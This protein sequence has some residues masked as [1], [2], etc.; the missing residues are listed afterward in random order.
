[1]DAAVDFY[2]LLGMRSVYGGRGEPFTTMAC[3]RSFV[4]LQAAD[5]GDAT[6][7]GRVILHVDSVATV[8][9]V[10]RT[11]LDAGHETETE[12]ADAVW[13]ER[14]FHVRDPDGHELSIAV[15]LP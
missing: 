5:P 9:A 4:N 10:H 15:R 11:L 8:D 13:G 3:G 6:R 2:E 14:Y 7:W 12:P 1:M